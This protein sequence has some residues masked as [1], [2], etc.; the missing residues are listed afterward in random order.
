MNYILVI[1]ERTNIAT[2]KEIE[3][4]EQPP[5]Y[6]FAIL[7]DKPTNEDAIDGAMEY[8]EA[9]YDFE[10]ELNSDEREIRKTFSNEMMFYS[11]AVTPNC[12]NFYISKPIDY[13]FTIVAE[14]NLDKFKKGIVKTLEGWKFKIDESIKTV[15]KF[16]V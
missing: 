16:T 15:E 13:E 5:K 6:S 3:L 7:K 12:C 8:L 9:N 10:Y 4:L 1:E 11:K 2:E 14:A